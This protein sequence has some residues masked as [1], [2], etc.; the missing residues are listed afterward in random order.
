MSDQASVETVGI[1]GA[2]LMGSGIAESVA[3]AGV[4]TLVYEPETAPLERSRQRLE[5]S[6]DLA[7]ER[8]KLELGAATEALER[9]THT[10]DLDDLLGCELVIEAVTEDERVKTDVFRRLDAALPPQAVLASN[11]SS[12]PIANLAAATSR[13]DRVV[14]LHFFSPVPVMRLVEVV[15]ALTTSSEV[16]RGRG[17]R[18]PDRKAPDSLP[19]PRRLP[20]QRAADP[21]SRLRRELVRPGL[22]DA[23]GHRRRHEA[24]VRPPHG[25]ADPMRL[26]R[27]GRRPRHLH[28]SWGGERLSCAH[29]RS[30][31]ATSARRRLCSSGCLGAPRAKG[32]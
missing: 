14:G 23:R 7:A 8:G 1:V 6:L 15:P 24:R 17:F 2:G 30:T 22:R 29:T 19:G 3:I 16:E 32:R 31:S 28:V 26:H 12:V 27:T 20:R 13:P 5:A 11:T 21:V 10:T 18:E 25:P 9:I 4:R